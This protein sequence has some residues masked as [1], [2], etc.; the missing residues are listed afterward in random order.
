[1][2]WFIGF[3]DNRTQCSIIPALGVIAAMEGGAVDLVPILPHGRA[4][5]A[6]L[7]K[8]MANL[9]TGPYRD[10]NEAPWPAARR[11][12]DVDLPMGVRRPRPRGSGLRAT[13][14]SPTVLG[15]HKGAQPIRNINRDREYSSTRPTKGKNDAEERRTPC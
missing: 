13:G 7:S 2:L 6:G 12:V 1:M 14:H 4:T 15:A 3:S 5:H 8:V 9:L 11:H 10:K